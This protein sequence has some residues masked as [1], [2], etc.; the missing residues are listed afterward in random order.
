MF[1]LTIILFGLVAIISTVQ[2]ATIYARQQESFSNG[3]IHQPVAGELLV[4]KAEFSFS[5]TQPN[6]ATFSQLNAT[7]A[8]PEGEFLWFFGE[9]TIANFG[10]PKR[11]IPAP[12][13][14]TA[15]D[16]GD[17]DQSLFFA[18]G[19]NALM[20]YSFQPDILN[21]YGLVFVPVSYSET[22]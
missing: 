7:G 18:S 11:G 8:F 14:L 20:N 6:A 22:D 16:L 12:P 21:E 1:S 2:G 5:Y 10:L 3:T 17:E 4:A 19:V 13:P 9:I 15:P